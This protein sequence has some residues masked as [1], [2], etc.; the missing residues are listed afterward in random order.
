M[1]KVNCFAFGLS[2][3]LLIPSLALAQ[4]TPIDMAVHQ[5][6]ENQANTIVLRQKLVEAQSIYQRGDILGAAKAYQ[7]CVDLAQQIGPGIETET[8]QAVAGLSTTSM[9]LAQDAQSRGDYREAQVRVNAVLKADP[10]NQAAIAFKQKNDQILDSLKGKLPSPAIMDEVPQIASQKVDAA[11]MVQDAKVLYEMGKLDDAQQKL[12]DALKLD[13]DNRA[14]YYYLNLIGE[15]N[16]ARNSAEHSL[17]SRLRM[18]QVEKQWV[19]PTPHVQL[20]VPNPYATNDLVYTGPGRQ[21]I[22]DKLN[23]IHLDE[24]NFDG[25]PLSEVLRQLSEQSK[26]R[27]PDRKGINFLINPNPDE[28]GPPI[29]VPQVNFG[30]GAGGG[31][32]GFAA[33]APLPAP[34][35]AQS[36]AIDPNTGLPVASPAGGGGSEPIDISSVQVKLDLSDVTLAEVLDAILLVAE[37]PS[38]HSIKYSVQDY[39][40][41][42]SDKGVET[43]QLMMRTFRVDPNT[44]Y[45]GLESVDAENFGSVQSSSTGGGAGGGAGGGGG[46]GGGGAAGA[47]G[48]TQNTGGVLGVVDA[49]PGA[50]AARQAG[51]QGGGGGATGG[52]G[53]AGGGSTDPLSRGGLPGG[54][55]GT[56]TSAG[57]LRYITTVNLSADVSLAARNFFTTLG[58]NLQ[59]PPGKSVF[60]ND[61]L[62]LLFVK[63]TEDDLDTIERAIQALD[64]L[65]PQVHIKARFIEVTENNSEALGFQW[66]LGQF[67]IGQGVVGQGGSSSSLNTTP[68]AANPLGVFPGTSTANE[69]QPS[70][71]DQSLTSGL[72]NTL[73]AP[74]LGTITGIFTQPNFQVALQALQQR[75]GVEQLAEPEATTISGRQTQMRATV[76]Q[77]V[78]TSFGFQQANTTTSLGVGGLP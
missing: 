21:I 64:Q 48:Q 51:S 78:V 5:S 49:V 18:D 57:G 67:N 9:L 29:A 26:L 34:T 39:G 50:A 24:V 76:L 8:A 62:G 38:G 77:S 74:T 63:A 45:S 75:D 52:A 33:P 46:G 42:F 44:F 65:P 16:Y 13:P 36:G 60:F 1:I 69:V 71:N 55:G 19:L 72:R 27:D 30:G 4:G 28:S 70:A 10:S 37:H 11:T 32:G 66:Y 23:R 41:V 35:T 12:R 25:L 6:V 58:I 59:S 15:A 7:E 53:G 3:L 40:V 68:S 31:G 17:D 2:A 47:G 20:P 43:P 22:M 54:A 14:A 61:R 56:S 73:G